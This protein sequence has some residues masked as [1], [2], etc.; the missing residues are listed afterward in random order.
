MTFGPMMTG[1]S[2]YSST[3]IMMDISYDKEIEKLKA[4]IQNSFMQFN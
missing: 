4:S 2:I 1:Y 3:T